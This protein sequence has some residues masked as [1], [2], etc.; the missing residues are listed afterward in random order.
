L[1]KEEGKTMTI[2]TEVSIKGFGEPG[3]SDKKSFTIVFDD[4]D[5]ITMTRTD[6]AEPKKFKRKK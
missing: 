4:A 2:D 6:K 1:A 3:K 5:T